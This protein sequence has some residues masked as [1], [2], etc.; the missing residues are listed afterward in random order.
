MSTQPQFYALFVGIDNY[1]S[2]N[3]TGLRGCVNDVTAMAGFVKAKLNLPE[4]NI[5]LYTA[6][7]RG[8]ETPDKLAS[9]ANILAGFEWLMGQA[10]AKDQIFIHYSGHGS[11][12][13][14]VDP[15]NEPDGLDETIVP[16]DSRMA[17]ADG[18]QVYDVLDKEI[19]TYIDIIEASGAYVTVFFDCCHSGSGTRGEPKVLTRKTP[20]DSRTR[21]LDTLEARTAARLAEQ[22]K[23]PP[24]PATV[25]GW[26][27]SGGH[28]LLA[29]C[30]DEELSHEY[31]DPQSGAW[32]G[33]TTYFLLR[34]LRSADEKTTWGQVYDRV[35]IQVNALYKN[36][37]PQLEGPENRTIFGGLIVPAHPHLLVEKVESDP[38]AL[39]I[40][41]NGGPPVG[42][43]VGSRIEL[44]PPG[45]GDLSGAP[46]AM[47][48]VESLDLDSVG[49]VWAKITTPP[50]DGVIPPFARVKISAQSYDS[51]V[52]PV[53]AADALVRAALTKVNDDG[54][55]E[56]ITP[57]LKLVEPAKPGESDGAIFRVEA[58]GDNFV[59]QDGSGVQIVV[60]R[61]PRTAEGAQQVANYLEHLAVYSNVRNL[62]NPTLSS[63]LAGALTVDAFSYS[64]A[65]RTRPED[66]IPLDN[67]NAVLEPGR[68][69]WLQVKNSGS[70]DLYLSIFVLT[71]D[72]GITRLYPPRMTSQRVVAGNE[73]SI[74]GI[75]P[76]INNPF[77]GRSLAI[78]KIFVTSEPIN[79]DVLRMAELNEPPI[80]EAGRTRGAGDPLSQLLNGVRSTGTRSGFTIEE[81][82]SDL[83]YTQQIEFT[84]LAANS[85]QELT[86]GATSVEI[87]SPLEMT[88]TKPADFT[89]QIVA[90]SVAQT[91]RGADVDALLKPPPGLSSGEASEMF[92]PLTFA[93]G[94]R[95]AIG[96]PGVLAVNAS[97]DELAQIN[98]ENPLRLELTLDEEEDLQGVLPIAFD[99]EHYF[100]A[101]QI[102][103]ATTGSRDPNRRRVALSITHLPLPADAYSSGGTRTA[104]DAPT[105]DLKRTARLFFYKVYKKEL[106]ADTGVR[107][108][109]FNPDF[110]PVRR[111]DGKPSYTAV[112][113]ADVAGAKR[114]GL[115][116]HGFTSD[117]T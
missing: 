14:T 81:D 42:L 51:L 83:W 80:P 82:T 47:G 53:A 104:G 67:P 48:V 100:L 40:Y 76:Q 26:H 78:F 64:R 20:E 74:P 107:R 70:E 66:G 75:A 4:A 17:G 8:D 87:G 113:P 22:V 98:E 16:C 6:N 39:F 36:Q 88:L 103:D 84:V 57:F 115:L 21:S 19:K 43:N 89:G 111:A 11:Q 93:S 62:R 49:Y 13:A 77:L 29:G 37:M 25:S 44:F 54:Q 90:S 117:T 97:P 27:I 72:F 73:F 61:P 63:R 110:T 45:S 38:S 52:Y 108:P 18:R 41:I 99:G 71:A 2:P 50:A 56:S 5:R 31:R 94:T 116:I 32:Q 86:P 91:T 24:Q 28:V 46:L 15:N 35:R 1:R 60:D 3:V 10:S 96:S 114:A 9:R 79:F 59:V 7:D 55:A 23:L 33:A 58:D 112:T 85:A 34:A 30:R 105:R 69:V 92:V 12:A 102:D 101:G 68:K 109:L 106:P 65:G 95:S